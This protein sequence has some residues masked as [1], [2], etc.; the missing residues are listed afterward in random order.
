[1]AFPFHLGDLQ[2]WVVHGLCA[3]Q[4][5]CPRNLSLIDILWNLDLHPIYT[6]ICWK[7]NVISVP[8]V[9]LPS[10]FLCKSFH[11][12][13]LRPPHWHLL[14]GLEVAVA[15]GPPHRRADGHVVII[16]IVGHHLVTAWC[17][18]CS[19][20]MALKK[21]ELEVLP[22]FCQNQMMES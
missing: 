12:H 5:L 4:L 19:F 18:S 22:H 17:I 1:M 14:Q 8:S 21:I 16:L 7:G 6:N 11:L 3:R 20:L 10:P 15:K 2:L 9:L 13:F